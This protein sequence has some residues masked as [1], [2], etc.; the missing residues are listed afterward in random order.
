[1]ATDAFLSRSGER[2]LIHS[3]PAS[4][5]R[6]KWKKG[7]LHDISFKINTG[8]KKAWPLSCAV[9]SHLHCYAIKWI[10][11]TIWLK[12]TL[13]KGGGQEQGGTIFNQVLSTISFMLVISAQPYTKSCSVEEGKLQ[14]NSNWSKL[15]NMHFTTSKEKVERT[16]SSLFSEI[17]STASFFKTR[18]K[19]LR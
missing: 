6:V 4:N 10:I 18:I 8:F 16:I 5:I 7:Q 15:C 14:P 19:Q 2:K 12:I 1:M 13:K 3:L 11:G 17:S 9:K